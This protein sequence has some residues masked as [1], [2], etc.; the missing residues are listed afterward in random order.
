MERITAAPAWEWWVVFYFFIGGLAAGLY[1]IAAMVELVGT[2]RDREMV[3]AAYYLAFPLSLV[4]AVLLI[5]DLG[6]PERFWHMLI[7]SE[8]GRLMFKVWSP[9][10]VGAWA[11]LV[12]GGLSLLSFVGVLAEDGRLGLGRWRG[13]ARALHHGPVGVGFELLCAGVGFFIASYTGVLLTATSQ[14]FWSD[15]PL[16]GALFLASAAATGTA[17]L[18]LVRFGGV[19]PASL[20]RLEK[21]NSWALGL[22]LLLLIGFFVSLGPLA[23]L[24]LGSSYGLL[25]LVVT[26]IFGVVLPLAWRMVPPLTGKWATVITCLLVLIGGFEM[27][28]SLLMAAQHIVLAGR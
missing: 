18:L 4:C 12:F 8:T 9:I 26:G 27:R 14:P 17:L 13:L 25:L 15:T 20:A 5:L 6:R 21:V 24:L 16:I 2:Q 22:E 3:K 7:Q 1:F 10:S 11:L 19:A 23:P 28:Y